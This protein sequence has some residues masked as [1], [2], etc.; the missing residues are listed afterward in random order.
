MTLE[1]V[2]VSTYASELV[3][4]EKVETIEIGLPIEWV[5]NKISDWNSLNDFLDSYT[6]D[7]TIGWLQQAIN[8]EVLLS[9]TYN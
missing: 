9:V 5:N 6:Y 8:D 1:I 3:N 4:D 7:D 2:E